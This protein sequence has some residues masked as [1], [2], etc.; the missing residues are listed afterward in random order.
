MGIQKRFWPGGKTKCLTFS[1][2]DGRTDDRRL[3][4][5]MSAYGIRGTFHLNSGF[6]ERDEYLSADEVAALFKG[7]EISAHTRS[8]PHLEQKQDTTVLRELIDDREALEKLAGYPV[9][10]M[11]YPYGAYDERVIS[12]CAA[13]GM[14]YARTTKPTNSFDLPERFLEWHP[15]GHHNHDIFAL[16]DRFLGIRS[17]WP[18]SLFFLWGHSYEFERDGNWDHIERFCERMGGREDNVVRHQY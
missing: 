4:G 10:G 13:A 1:Y 2:D 17:T 12:L 3:V 6:F 18:H 9:R 15:T 11:S 7:H 16:A 8:H 14:E 5:I